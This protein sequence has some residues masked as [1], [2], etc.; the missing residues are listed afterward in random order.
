MPAASLHRTLAEHGGIRL[1]LD[2]PEGLCIRTDLVLAQTL[3]RNLLANA[4]KF[5][6]TQVVIR[7]QA[8]G[9]RVRLTVG[10]DGPPLPAEVAARLAGDQDEPMTAT[11]GMG[12]KLCREICSVL[13]MPL[14]TNLPPE[15]GTEFSFTLKSAGREAEENS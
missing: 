11:G 7:A 1:V 13:G 8:E 14:E 3:V 12:L 4:L 6:R 15:G 9:S 2:V 10:N 5:A